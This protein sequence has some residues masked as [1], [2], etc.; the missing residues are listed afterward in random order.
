MYVP[1]P[2][3]AT[4]VA[5][6]LHAPLQLTFTCDC[7]AVICGGWVIVNVCVPEQPA[8]SVAVHVYDPAHNPEAVAPEPPLGDHAY[9]NGAVPP[10]TVTEAEPLHDPKH[11]TFVCEPVIVSEETVTVIVLVT[12]AGT[13]LQFVDVSCSVYTVVAVGQT[14]ATAVPAAAFTVV[15]IAE[16]P[17]YHETVYVAAPVGVK[18]LASLVV[19]HCVG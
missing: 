4:T 19:V 11:V 5:L 13:P 16:A 18:R 2:P 15:A 3:E 8:A 12:V 17:W 14:V 7:V 10:V 6:P 9:V 1:V